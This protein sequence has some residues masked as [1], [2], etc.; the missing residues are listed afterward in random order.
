MLWSDSDV[1]AIQDM[2]DGLFGRLGLTAKKDGRIYR[3]TKKTRD[4]VRL[5]YHAGTFSDIKEV[6]WTELKTYESTVVGAKP[7]VAVGEKV[8]RTDPVLPK[9]VTGIELEEG[10]V[11]DD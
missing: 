4:G 5:E 10:D 3:L 11:Y 1:R 7:N 2:S 6:S 9:E 8:D